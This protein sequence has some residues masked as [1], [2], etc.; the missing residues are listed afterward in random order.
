M[1][2]LLLTLVSDFGNGLRFFELLGTISLEI[3]LVHITILHPLAYWGYVE[4]FNNRLYLILPFI[5]VAIAWL[6]KQ[7]SDITRRIIHL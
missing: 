2:V 6:V 4:R 5:S 1:T 7:L 3:Y